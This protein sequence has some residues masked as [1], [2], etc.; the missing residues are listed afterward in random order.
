MPAS[1]N[2]RA[3]TP[4]ARRRLSWR[5]AP[6][7]RHRPAQPGVRKP[8]SQNPGSKGSAPDG[9]GPASSIQAGRRPFAAVRAILFRPYEIDQRRHADVA[10]A[11]LQRTAVVV[12]IER[13]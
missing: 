7:G 4:F 3:P 9:G 1:G 6:R 12:D 10:A 8:P 5:G 13:G 11:L 2:T